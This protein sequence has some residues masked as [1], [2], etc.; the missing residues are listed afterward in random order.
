LFFLETILRD[1]TYA[2]DQVLDSL[3]SRKYDDIMAFYLLL[4]LRTT[5]VIKSLFNIHF[6]IMEFVFFRQIQQKIQLFNYQ[7]IKVLQ[8]LQILNQHY[9]QKVFHQVHDHQQQ[10]IKKIFHQLINNIDHQQLLQQH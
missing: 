6:L 3:V 10:M 5:E 1:G 9:H 8:I 7:I 4:G 2:R